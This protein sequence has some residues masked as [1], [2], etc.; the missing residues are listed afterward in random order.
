MERLLVDCICADGTVQVAYEQQWR[1]MFKGQRLGYLDDSFPPRPTDA[2]RAY[3][4]SLKV[5]A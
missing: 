4:A 2:G 3:L 1:T 5:T